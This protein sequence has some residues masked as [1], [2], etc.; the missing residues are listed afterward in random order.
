MVVEKGGAYGDVSVDGEDFREK[1]SA[2]REA[3][4]EE[5]GDAPLVRTACGHH[6]APALCAVEDDRAA[7][8]GG[9]REL[10]RENGALGVW[11]GLRLQ[12][13]KADF[14]HAGRGIGH[15]LGADGIEI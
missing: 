3:V 11:Y 8:F 2:A 14:S 4:E 10:L 1:A 15:E 9:E 7:E 12:A 5:R 13:V 6:L